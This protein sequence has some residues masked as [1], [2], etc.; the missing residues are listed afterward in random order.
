MTNFYTHPDPMPPVYAGAE[1]DEQ[2]ALRIARKRMI[3]T[4]LL[5]VVANACEDFHAEKMKQLAGKSVDQIWETFCADDPVEITDYERDLISAGIAAGAASVKVPE[6]IAKD[7]ARYRWLEDPSLEQK[8]GEPYVVCIGSN[9]DA[10][11][12]AAML[13]AAPSAP[14]ETK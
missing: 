7:A 2:L 9:L 6:D 13:S 14:G 10:A 8:E 12:D 11:I 5:H 3:P 4:E 1:S